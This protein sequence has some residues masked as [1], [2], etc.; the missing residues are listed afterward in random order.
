MKSLGVYLNLVNNACYIFNMQEYYIF[1]LQEYYI[2]FRHSSSILLKNSDAESWASYYNKIRNKLWEFLVKR[3][4]I[5]LAELKNGITFKKQTSTRYSPSTFIHT[6][7]FDGVFKWD[8]NTLYISIWWFHFQYHE[9]WD[10]LNNIY[11]TS[12]GWDWGNFNP[13]I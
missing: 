3:S 6:S 8:N 1:N 9:Y 12:V 11:R 13:Q 4:L 7:L 5:T 10:L 2:Y